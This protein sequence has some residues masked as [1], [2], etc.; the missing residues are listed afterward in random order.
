MFR[1][2][3]SDQSQDRTFRLRTNE[4]SLISVHVYVKNN[5]IITVFADTHKQLRLVYITVSI[6]T[7]ETLESNSLT[8]QRCLYVRHIHSDLSEYF[9]TDESDSSTTIPEIYKVRR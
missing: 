4:N 8:A 5:A 1:A 9:G 7:S 2:R 3:V 6:M